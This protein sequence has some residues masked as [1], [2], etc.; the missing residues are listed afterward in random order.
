MSYYKLVK[1]EKVRFFGLVDALRN[2]TANGADNHITPYFNFINAIV[3]RP[4]DVDIRVHLR[5]EFLRLGIEEIIDV[6]FIIFHINK[7]L[8]ET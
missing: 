3:T 5:K 7:I 8:I 2:Y 6:I 1:R 4:L